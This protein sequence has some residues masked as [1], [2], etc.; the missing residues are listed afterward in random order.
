MQ[1]DIL[2]KSAHAAKYMVIFR[3]LSQVVTLGVTIMLVRG[4]SQHDYG[5]YNLLYSIIGLFSI[6]ASFGIA[7]TLQRYMP[8]YYRRGEF[9]IANNLY[10]LASTIRLVSNA[11]VLGLLLIFWDHLAHL[12]KIGEYRDYFMLFCVIV[13]LYMQRGILEVCLGAYF[14]QKSAQG[15]AFAF[16][17]IRG[18]GYVAAILTGMNLWRVLLVDL[19]AYAVLFAGLQMVYRVKIPKHEGTMDRIEGAEKKRLWRYALFYNFND[20]GVGLIKPDIDY[21]LIAYFFNPAQVA[22]YAFCQRTA[23]LLGKALP[24]K[25]L[26]D[27]VRPAFFAAGTEMDAAGINRIFQLLLK[28][29]YLVNIPVFCFIASFGD[30]FIQ[31]VFGSQYVPYARVLA[32][33]CFFRLASGFDIPVNLVAQLEEK[34]DVIL[35]SK[36]FAVYNLIADIIL[37]RYFGIWGAVVATGT[38]VF[39]KNFFIWWYVRDLANLKGMGP[40]MIKTVGFWTVTALAVGAVSRYIPGHLVSLLIGASVFG[41]AFMLQFRMTLFS[42]QDK[43]WLQK[44][45][46]GS[47]RGAYFLKLFRLQPA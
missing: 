27:V 38:A 8:E 26:I 20:A 11:V 2:Q 1:K 42:E 21:F 45:G 17:L 19:A 43:H 7:N 3:V 5:V 47:R 15:L 32:A 37:I 6:I 18:V 10:R 12:L 46:Q 35:Y 30:H 41:L 4:L 39:G 33:V 40:F 28:S 9:R 25:Y 34:A 31:I 44:A 22:A 24:V 16:E 29:S 14:L 36:I 23:K 13:L